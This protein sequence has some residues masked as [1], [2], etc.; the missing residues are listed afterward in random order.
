MHFTGAEEDSLAPLSRRETRGARS[1][2]QRTAAMVLGCVWLGFG[3]L[4]ALFVVLA[5]ANR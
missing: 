4:I 2:A 5:L 3:L 1:E